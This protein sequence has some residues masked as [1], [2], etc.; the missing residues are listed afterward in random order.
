MYVKTSFFDVEYEVKKDSFF[1]SAGIDIFKKNNVHNN[2][3]R[4]LTSKS[5][6]SKFSLP[7]QSRV[8]VEFFIRLKPETLYVRKF[9]EL[10]L[11]S[12]SCFAYVKK[13]KNVLTKAPLCWR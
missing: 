11:F 6:R 13:E 8:N 4:N 12:R 3:F 1:V 9:N 7:R 10:F 5:S 2:F